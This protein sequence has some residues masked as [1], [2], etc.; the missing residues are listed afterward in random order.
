MVVEKKLIGCLC[1]FYN[2]NE[3]TPAI[4]ILADIY[5]DEEYPEQ[6][7]YY[8][9]NGGVY[10]RCEPVKEGEFTLYADRDCTTARRREAKKDLI[11]TIEDFLEEHISYYEE[12]YE[13]RAGD[14]LEAALD[15]KLH[16]TCL[17]DEK[18]IEKTK[19]LMMKL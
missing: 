5:N 9:L 15:D 19:Q 2:R 1:W 8:A 16:H 6:K 17:E 18:V 14:Y 12:K 10:S 7:T 3:A 4:G 11:N 13:G